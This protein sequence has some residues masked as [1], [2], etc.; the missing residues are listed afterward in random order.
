MDVIRG[1]ALFGVL[2]VNLTMIDATM[3][4]YVASPLLHVDLL[5]QMASWAIHIFAVGKFYTSFSM[6]FGLG[7]YYFLNKPGNLLKMN[8]IISVVYGY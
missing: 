5:D 7:F 1:F 6:L 8:I 2:L 3:Y 4:S